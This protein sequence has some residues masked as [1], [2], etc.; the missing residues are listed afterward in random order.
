VAHLNLPSS[1]DGG[2]S[3]WAWAAKQ[4]GYR[5]VVTT[6]HLPM[7]ER[8]YRRFPVKFFFTHWVDAAIA[9]AEC[10]RSLLTDRHGVDSH[11][12]LAIP[13]GVERPDR[14][15]AEA[16]TRLRREWGSGAGGEEIVIGNVARLTARKGQLVLLRALAQLPPSY[17]LVLVGEGEDEPLLRKT[18]AELGIEDRVHFA[19]ARPDAASLP[20]AF[21]L[22]VLPSFVET[23][24][25]TVLEAMAGGTAVVAS[26]V[27]G[28][29]EILGHG[30]SGW[31]VPAGDAARLAGAIGLLGRDRALR[32]RLARAGQ[33]RYEAEFTAARMAARTAAVYL[34]A[35]S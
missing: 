7:I 10:N 16:R 13:N 22:F 25:L 15:S 6:E 1:Y 3:S 24:P 18:A 9:I 33:A 27:Y 8:K 2:I 19:G 26:A 32:E 17:R 23:M 20:Q 4:R 29:P 30:E 21:D 34:G 35:A 12:V 5:R 28:L 11:K 31:L 14:L